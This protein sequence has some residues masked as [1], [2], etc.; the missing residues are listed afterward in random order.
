MASRDDIIKMLNDD[1][2]GEVEAILV[3]MKNHFVC[4]RD[5]KTQLEMLEIALD[6]MRHVQWLAEAIVELGGTPE[7]APR[8]LRFAGDDPAEALQHG[9]NL[10]REAIEQYDKHIA[11]IDDPKIQRM[12]AHIRDEEVDHEEEFK[13]LLEE[14]REAR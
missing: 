6:E 13:E 12:L 10:E 4:E 5:C 14:W 2:T 9:V 3:Y 1:L 7:L 11:A 8:Q